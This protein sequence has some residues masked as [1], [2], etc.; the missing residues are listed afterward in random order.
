[1]RLP[2]P[3]VNVNCARALDLSL[4]SLSGNY[5]KLQGTAAA[6]RHPARRD[7]PGHRNYPAVTVMH[8]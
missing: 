1:L 7:K 3:S 2:E 8:E 6:P 4:A 5:D